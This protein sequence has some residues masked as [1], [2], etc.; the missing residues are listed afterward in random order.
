MMKNYGYAP[1]QDWEWRSYDGKDV[2]DIAEFIKNNDDCLFFIGTDSKNYPKNRRCVFTTALIAYRI[3]KGGAVIMHRDKTDFMDQLRPRLL[4]EAMRS[5]ETAW[6]LDGKLP[7]RNI[8]TIHLDVNKDLKFKSGK[9]KD[10]LLGMV[11][12]QGFKTIVKPDSWASSSVADRG[13]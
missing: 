2:I 6:Y 10:E 4:M 9:Y 7:S 11:I 8:I 13:C 1:F 3:G 12:A 5:L